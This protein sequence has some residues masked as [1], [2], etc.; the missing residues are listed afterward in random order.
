MFKQLTSCRHVLGMDISPSLVSALQ[1]TR[2]R[3]NYVIDKFASEPLPLHAIVDHQI[4]DSDAIINCIKKL[5]TKGQFIG[6]LTV[7]AVPDSAI[8][9]KTIQISNALSGLQI[10]DA[11]FAEASKHFSYSLA[12]INLDF[13]IIGNSST[14]ID[15]LDVQ[16]TVC[17]AEHVASR[18]EVMNRVGLEVTA[19][20]TDACA[21]TRVESYLAKEINGAVCIVLLNPRFIY[22]HV[23]LAGKIIF[24]HE[25]VIGN[26]PWGDEHN[27]KD[28]EYV[29]DTVVRQI[30]RMLQ[31]FE[32]THSMLTIEHLFLAGAMTDLSYLRLRVQEKIRITTSVANPFDDRHPIGLQTLAPS[33]MLA[34]GLALRES[35]HA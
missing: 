11:V 6:K 10:E 16:L 26:N 1:I 27:A 4:R 31:F 24:S 33:M 21:L 22:L 12:E 35:H 7:L 19:I 29:M 9:T 14:H 23:F 13:A 20:E 28:K 8:V 5:L 18:V 17:R 25:E 30:K 3:N 32:S 2:S 34:F 15:M